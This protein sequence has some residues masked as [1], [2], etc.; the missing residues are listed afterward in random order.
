[1]HNIHFI[2]SPI[3][4]FVL[5]CKLINVLTVVNQCYY[6][7]YIIVSNGIHY[8]HLRFNKFLIIIVYKVA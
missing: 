8:K 2:E 4:C 7:Y 5:F 3:F 6:Y 1:M